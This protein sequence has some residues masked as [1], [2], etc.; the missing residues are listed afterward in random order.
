MYFLLSPKTGNSPK[1]T[2]LRSIYHPKIHGNN[3]NPNIKTL[4]SYYFRHFPT[5][6]THCTLPSLTRYL[7][8][9]KRKERQK[10]KLTSFTPFPTN[11]TEKEKEG[12]RTRRSR[13]KRR[14]GGEGM[15]LRGALPFPHDIKRHGSNGHKKP[16]ILGLGF[17]GLAVVQH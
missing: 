8:Q 1:H 6:Q 14:I 4:I 10:L 5:N 7:T 17:F 13:R 2:P 12:K 3:K 9:K 15:K 16:P 11:Q